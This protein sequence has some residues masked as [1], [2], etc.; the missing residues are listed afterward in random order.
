MK[1]YLP[2]L[3]HLVM[4]LA[5][6][7]IYTLNLTTTFWHCKKTTLLLNRSVHLHSGLNTWLRWIGQRQP[8]DVTRIISVVGVGACNIRGFTVITSY[9]FIWMELPILGQ[10]THICVGNLNTISSDGGLSPSRRQAIIWNN[11]GILLIGP[12]ETNFSEILIKI[13][14]F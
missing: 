4:Q 10:V 1:F 3:K 5:K 9:S 11:A 8:Q 14:T 7:Q 13:H 12:L 2:T 6:L